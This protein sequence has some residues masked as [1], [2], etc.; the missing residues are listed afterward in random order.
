SISAAAA[1]ILFGEGGS[2]GLVPPWSDPRLFFI[3][4]AGNADIQLP[5][6]AINVPPTQW[7]GID[8]LSSDNLRDSMEGIDPTTAEKAIGVLSPTFA[9]RARSNLRELAF[10]ADQ[11][12]C[13]FLPDSTPTSFDKRNVRDGHYSIW[14]PLHLFAAITNGVPSPAASALV[15]RFVAP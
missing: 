4:S 7:W 3:R 12:I 14:G 6:H 10:E 15:T 1:H 9:D 11:Q 2:N 13:G 8:R 5:A